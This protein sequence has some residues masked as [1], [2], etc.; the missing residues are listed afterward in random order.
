M[1]NRIAVAVAFLALGACSG[2]SAGVRADLTL[3]GVCGSV[4]STLSSLRIYSDGGL[5]T[6]ADE[7]AIDHVVAVTR[8]FCKKG[9]LITNVKIAIDAV[10][11]ELERLIIMKAAAKKGGT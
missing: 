8:P 10:E 6:D 11:I 3:A 1:L 4:G 5:L 2:Q 7:R 9:A